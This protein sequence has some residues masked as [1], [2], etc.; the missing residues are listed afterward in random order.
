[1]PT[2]FPLAANSS[3]RLSHPREFRYIL[4]NLHDRV[5]CLAFKSQKCLTMACQVCYPVSFCR[6]KYVQK[7]VLVC[8][9]GIIGSSFLVAAQA[10]TRISLRWALYRTGSCYVTELLPLLQEGPFSSNR[11]Y[12]DGS[13]LKKKKKKQNR[14]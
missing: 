14:I 4:F 13:V 6:G 7:R 8:L 12:R 11:D 1:M 3:G 9:Y 5:G 2:T 10:G